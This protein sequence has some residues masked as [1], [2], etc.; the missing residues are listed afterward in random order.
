M[1]TTVAIVLGGVAAVNAVVD[2]FGMY[3]VVE[4]PGHNTYKPAIA[5]RVRLLKAYEVRRLQPDSILLSSSRGHAPFRTTH[6]GWAQAAKRRYNLAFDGAT[7]SEM[8]AYLRHAAAGGALELVLLGLDS[9]HPAIRTVVNKPDFDPSRLRTGGGWDPLRMAVADARL[10][11]SVD[12]L[13]ETLRT[14]ESQRAQDPEVLSLAPDG[15]RAG[16]VR[17][18]GRTSFIERGPRAYFD[19]SVREFVGDALASRIPARRAG[20][21]AVAG[22]LPPPDPHTS[23]DYIREIVRFCRERNID[24]RIFLT[25][26]HANAIEVREAT[27]TWGWTDDGK[28]ALVRALAEDAAAHPGARPV[29]LYDFDIV[30]SI[31]TEPLP[32][33]GS[34]DE[35]RFFWDASHAK[36]NVGDMILDWIFGVRAPGNG[37]PTDVG[38]MLTPATIESALERNRAAAVRWRQQHPEDVARIA[39]WVGAFKR[40]HGIVD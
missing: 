11:V 36:Q 24:L 4:W 2:P 16:E 25:P 13:S 37:L 7:T 20:T 18:R 23:L 31:T 33:D 28:R 38:V 29:P 22:A 17:Y 12:T 15:Q 3:R 14:L 6:A 1:V 35:M 40:T 9:Y 27:G 32:A 34:R 5:H 8:L 30:S 26:S 21:P 19:E 39:S 10:L